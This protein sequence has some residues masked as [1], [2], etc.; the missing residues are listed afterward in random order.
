MTNASQCKPVFLQFHIPH[1]CFYTEKNKRSQA[2]GAE[3]ISTFCPNL[4]WL[5]PMFHPLFLVTE[6]P[7][8]PCAAAGHLWA[9]SHSGISVGVGHP[10]EHPLRWPT[11]HQRPERCGFR[12]RCGLMLQNLIDKKTSKRTKT[13]DCP[14]ENPPPNFNQQPMHGGLDQQRGSTSR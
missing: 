9:H 14:A 12:P 13:L 4:R 8:A 6:T 2:K 10:E 7:H 1:G 11:S 5:F 3:I